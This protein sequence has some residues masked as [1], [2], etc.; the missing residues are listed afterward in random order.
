MTSKTN[1]PENNSQTSTNQPIEG[2]DGMTEKVVHC[3]ISFILHEFSHMNYSL[4]NPNYI[5]SKNMLILLFAYLYI[6][7]R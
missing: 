4:D 6:I 2:K 7:L 1:E 3:S 5:I